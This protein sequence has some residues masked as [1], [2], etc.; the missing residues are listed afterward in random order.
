[1]WIFRVAL[2][3]LLSDTLASK[4]RDLIHHMFI[5]MDIFTSWSNQCLLVYQVESSTEWHLPLCEIN[6]WPGKVP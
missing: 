6:L 4:D 2:P 5:T 1:M 3:I